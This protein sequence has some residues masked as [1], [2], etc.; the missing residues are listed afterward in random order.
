MARNFQPVPNIGTVGQNSLRGRLANILKYTNSLI[1]NIQE[2]KKTRELGLNNLLL[3]NMNKFSV[4]LSDLFVAKQ[5]KAMEIRI[6]AETTTIFYQLTGSLS[7][8]VK[9][10]QRLSAAKNSKEFFTDYITK[11]ELLLCPMTSLQTFLQRQ[12]TEFPSRDILTKLNEAFTANNQL[13]L[14]NQISI[15]SAG[16][17][18]S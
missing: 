14:K 6:D 13:L 7:M 4:E 18:N 9:L 1:G 12:P 15:E 16:I 5:S 17:Q 2:I 10:N 8:F 3:Q 11:L